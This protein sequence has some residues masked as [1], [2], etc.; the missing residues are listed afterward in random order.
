MKLW[1]RT[2]AASSAT[3]ALA[4]FG[5]VTLASGGSEGAGYH[6]AHMR[7]SQ[8][9]NRGALPNAVMPA[10]FLAQAYDIG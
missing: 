1:R 7:W 3:D 6:M 4:P 10:T 5:I 2:W 8:T 9:G